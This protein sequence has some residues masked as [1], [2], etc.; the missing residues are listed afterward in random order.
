MAPQWFVNVQDT[1]RLHVAALIDPACN[2]ER[3]FAFAA[4]FNGNDILAVLRKLYPK[5]KF[6]DD[7]PDQGKDITEIPNE[8]AEELLRKRYGKG[9]SGLEETLRENFAGMSFD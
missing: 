3:I 9:F 2:G 7:V 1:A 4:P 6:L 5:R 8:D